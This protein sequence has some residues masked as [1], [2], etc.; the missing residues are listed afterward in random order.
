MI[1][2]EDLVVKR[3]GFGIKPKDIERVIGRRARVAIE[4]D[5]II[6]WDMV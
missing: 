2:R 6:T 4:A 5:D 1:T 3:P